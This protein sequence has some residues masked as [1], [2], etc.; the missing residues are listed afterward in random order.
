MKKKAKLFY[1]G[2]S[3]AV[4]LPKEFRM[5]GKEVY[6]SRH[7]NGVVLKPVERAKLVTIG[8]VIEH[9]RKNFPPLDDGFIRAVREHREESRRHGL[10]DFGASHHK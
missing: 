5:P 2:R 7:G 4:R 3:Q 8:D 9:F 6:I 10:R 1:N